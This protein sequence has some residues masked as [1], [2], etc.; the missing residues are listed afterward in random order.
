LIFSGSWMGSRSQQPGPRP[1]D[2]SPSLSELPN[3]IRC[4]CADVGDELDHAGVQ[5]SL[6]ACHDRVEPSLDCGRAIGLASCDRVDEKQLLL[7]SEGE[8]RSLPEGMRFNRV[9]LQALTLPGFDVTPNYQSADVRA[10]SWR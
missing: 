6:D 10:R 2:R 5:F 8:W 3:D 1:H 4:T 7:R 9:L